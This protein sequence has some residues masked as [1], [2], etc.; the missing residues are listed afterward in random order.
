MCAIASVQLWFTYNIYTKLG[1]KKNNLDTRL[2]VHTTS[3]LGERLPFRCK[4]NKFHFT[5]SAFSVL[6]SFSRRSACTTSSFRHSGHH[7]WEHD[8]ISFTARTIHR[9]YS[10]G[11]KEC[12]PDNCLV[13]LDNKDTHH[14]YVSWYNYKHCQDQLTALQWISPGPL[15][16]LYWQPLLQIGL[17]SW[18]LAARQRA[19]DSQTLAWSCSCSWWSTADA[20]CSIQP[21]VAACSLQVSHHSI[22][23]SAWPTSL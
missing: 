20:R 10:Q 18:I 23:S 13:N 3:W 8:S 9:H 6:H 17:T 14:P 12:S 16:T 22:N 7:H 4:F 19:C 1:E 11:V 21:E 2:S 5:V 15:Y